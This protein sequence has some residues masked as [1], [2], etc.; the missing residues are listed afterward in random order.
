MP[1]HVFNRGNKISP[2]SKTPQLSANV[3]D[4]L[5]ILVL[6]YDFIKVGMKLHYT[7]DGKCCLLGANYLY[8]QAS[9]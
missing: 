3:K 2:V 7:I 5:H 4:G 8:C 9:K 1:I 6:R